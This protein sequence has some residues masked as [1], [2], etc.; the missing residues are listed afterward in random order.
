VPLS[1]SRLRTSRHAICPGSAIGSGAGHRGSVPL[2]VVLAGQIWALPAGITNRVP[3]EYGTQ[4]P[5]GKPYISS[6]NPEGPEI[7]RYC[8]E[9]IAILTRLASHTQNHGAAIASSLIFTRLRAD[10]QRA[11]DRAEDPGGQTGNDSAPSAKAAALSRCRPRLLVPGRSYVHP[12]RRGIHGLKNR[13]S[14]GVHQTRRVPSRLAVVT[15]QNKAF[16]AIRSHQTLTPCTAH[17]RQ[18]DC[19]EKVTVL[20]SL[21]VTAQSWRG[22]RAAGQPRRPVRGG[23]GSGSR[24]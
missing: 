21:S 12:R 23:R 6:S 19:A 13:T 15:T 20:R 9:T 17:N 2:P 14:S 24:P 10:A 7:S 3:L 22:R 8:R 1:Q 11:A 5:S 18:G 4:F 16:C